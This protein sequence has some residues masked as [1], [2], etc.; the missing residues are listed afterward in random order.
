[1]AAKKPELLCPAGDMERLQMA[2]AYGADAVYL[3]GT[4]FGMRAF[5]G[6]F[7]PEEL[8]RAVAYAHRWAYFRNPDYLDFSDLGGD[9]THYASQ[10]IF[11]GSGIMNYTPELGWYYISSSDRTAAWTGVNFLYNFSNLSQKIYFIF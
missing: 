11:A 5:A 1:M 4:S 8:P 6:N 10:C 2:V 9:C 7:S 3:A